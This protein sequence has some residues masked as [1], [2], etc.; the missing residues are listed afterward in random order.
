[1]MRL[2]TLALLAAALPASANDVFKCVAN[3]RTVYQN[4][5]C[6]G[7][8]VQKQLKAYRSGALLG[9]YTVDL[10]GFDGIF[11][12][13]RSDK[14]DLR[15]EFGEP[16]RRTQLPMKVA[17]GAEVKL[18]ADTFRQPVTEGVSVR[19]DE[20]SRDK[21]P[22]GVYKGTDKLGQEQLFAHFVYGNGPA[23]RKVCP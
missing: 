21:R 18:V 6:E 12:V 2:A 7:P 8:A 5:P 11:E 15:L 13:K 22:I 3:G 9:C 4:T 10:P 17:T 1:M 19:W 20:N 16:G 23:V 14:G